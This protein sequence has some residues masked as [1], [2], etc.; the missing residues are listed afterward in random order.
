MLA[1]P[2]QEFHLMP[3]FNIVTPEQHLIPALRAKINNKTKP[4]GARWLC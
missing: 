3:A 1:C 2:D 4:L